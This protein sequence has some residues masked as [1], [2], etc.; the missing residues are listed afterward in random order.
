M[1]MTEVISGPAH[2]VFDK[3]QS[4]VGNGEALTNANGTDR[5]SAG[6]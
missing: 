1:L 4:H 3:G 6:Q 2:A 5:L